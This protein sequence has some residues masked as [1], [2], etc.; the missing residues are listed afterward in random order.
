MRSTN[1]LKLG[2][3]KNFFY[4]KRKKRFLVQIHNN[5]KKQTNKSNKYKCSYIINWSYIMNE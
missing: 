1:K 4:K 3:F 5:K 2:I